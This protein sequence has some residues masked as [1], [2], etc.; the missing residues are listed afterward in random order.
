M[1]SDLRNVGER[2]IWTFIQTGI[3]V[4]I[5]NGAL[6]LGANS[7]QIAA[8]SGAGAALSVLKEFA[9]KRTKKLERGSRKEKS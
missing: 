5:A 7:I 6:D 4:L 1:W 8:A 9:K 3:G 2:A